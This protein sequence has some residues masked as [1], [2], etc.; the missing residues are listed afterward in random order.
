MVIH[1]NFADIMLLT[2]VILLAGL[3]LWFIF[4]R[5]KR[6]GG[7]SGGCSGCRYSGD[8]PSAKRGEESEK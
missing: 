6:G 5:K 2:A 7:C 4:R 8:C 1:M 3:A